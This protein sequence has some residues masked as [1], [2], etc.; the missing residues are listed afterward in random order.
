MP[1]H[2][3]PTFWSYHQPPPS[4][5]TRIQNSPS[6]TLSHLCGTSHHLTPLRHLAAEEIP[7]SNYIL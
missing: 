4:A 7:V 5:S 6:R 3:P 2:K 1:Y